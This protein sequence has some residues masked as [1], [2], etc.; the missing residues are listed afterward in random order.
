MYR[1]SFPPLPRPLLQP[2]LHDSSIILTLCMQAVLMPIFA[3][4]AVLMPIFAHN[5]SAALQHILLPICILDKQTHLELQYLL[6]LR[7]H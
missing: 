3:C 4:C 2:L 1:L 6:H 5:A 7:S